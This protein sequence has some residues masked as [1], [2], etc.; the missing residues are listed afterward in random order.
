MP[1]LIFYE[2]FVD[3][4]QPAQRLPKP[5]C[6]HRHAPFTV[7]SHRIGFWGGF[8][9]PDR[10]KD[11]PSPRKRV[12][13]GR[14]W[15]APGLRPVPTISHA[16]NVPMPGSSNSQYCDSDSSRR[17]RPRLAINTPLT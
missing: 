15:L 3:H 1:S 14:G 16:L 13:W 11:R 10:V 7:R 8:H 4:R 17:L 9:R 6:S 12:G 2:T 5:R